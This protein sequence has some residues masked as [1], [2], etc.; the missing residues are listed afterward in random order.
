MVVGIRVESEN[1]QTGKINHCNSSYFTMVSK[2]EDGK[3]ARVPG[4]I[5]S[6]LEEVRRFCNCI[7]QIALKKEKDRHEENFNYS[8]IETLESLE[9]YNVL[10]QIG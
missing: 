3:N 6:N 9:K 1:I 7:K 8:S 4:L 2:D 10:V 5:L